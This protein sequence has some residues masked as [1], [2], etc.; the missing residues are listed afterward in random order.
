[1]NYI[2]IALKTINNGEDFVQA[3]ADKY[4]NP[5]VDLKQ[6]PDWIKNILTLID[7]D[8]ELQMDGLDFKSYK[9]V[10]DALNDVGLYEEAQA[11]KEL[12]EDSSEKSVEECYSKLAINN[13][14]EMFWD[15]VFEYADKNLNTDNNF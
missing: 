15:T 3:M 14:Y 7:Y 1:M 13:D 11:L 6:Y 10:I 4:S 8:T 5:E 2:D 9:N 12:E